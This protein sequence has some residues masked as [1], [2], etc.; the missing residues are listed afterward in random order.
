MFSRPAATVRPASTTSALHD[1][2]F[3]QNSV[4]RRDP[5]QE[6]FTAMTLQTRVPNARQTVAAALLERGRQSNA[7]GVGRELRR[8]KRCPTRIPALLDTGSRFQST[9]IEDLSV[10]G[11]GLAGAYGVLP[12]DEI[13]LQLLNGRALAG[14]VRWWFLGRCGIAFRQQLAS[15][16]PLL[17]EAA[18]RNAR[19]TARS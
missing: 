11:A 6:G 2:Q 3:R 9:T 1:N 5:T 16:D 8:H 18:A 7:A 10:G 17:I 19:R 12:G 13:V 15:D 14:T 4:K